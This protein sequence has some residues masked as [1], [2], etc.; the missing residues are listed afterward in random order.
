MR[1]SP[2]IRSSRR[3]PGPKAG[4]R[5]KRANLVGLA[6]ISGRTISTTE[7]TERRCAP[8]HGE[9]GGRANARH[10]TLQ[11]PQ[12]EIVC[13]AKPRLRVLRAYS[14]SSVVNLAKTVP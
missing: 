12:L 4:R 1:A 11:A 3:R 13:S 5:C 8:S 6:P 10:E 9:H 2:T 7:D 14:V